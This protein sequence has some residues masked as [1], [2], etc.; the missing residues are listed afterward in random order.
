MKGPKLKS[1]NVMY[2]NRTCF[3][4][5][6]IMWTASIS[7]SLIRIPT[8]DLKSLLQKLAII[9]KFMQGVFDFWETSRLPLHDDHTL[10]WTKD[11]GADELLLSAA[12]FNYSS[13]VELVLL[14]GD[15]FVFWHLREEDEMKF[16]HSECQ[17]DS[18]DKKC[19]NKTCMTMS[20]GMN[21]EF[22][23]FRSCFLVADWKYSF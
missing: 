4:S 15:A 11:V 1:L 20:S 18:L 17:R 5:T 14:C 6:G 2:K 19:C 7:L 3:L 8:F 13:S 23:Y 22:R 9:N 10:T 21:D 12:E 16:V